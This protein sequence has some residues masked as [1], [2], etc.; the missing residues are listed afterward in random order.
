MIQAWVPWRAKFLNVHCNYTEI[1]CVPS[2]THVIYTCSQNKVLSIKAFVTVCFLTPLY[3]IFI[4][5]LKLM[6]FCDRTM[7]SSLVERYQVA[8]KPADSNF[9]IEWNFGTSVPHHT[10]SP[11]QN[12]IILLFRAM[13]TSN[14][15]LC[16][17]FSS[18]I[19]SNYTASN[20]WMT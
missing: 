9:M 20:N 4:K 2:A 5:H 12:T 3:I 11:P 10:S 15:T 13:R 18:V 17:L 8:R 16:T 19:S 14:V 6:V 1:W 7:A